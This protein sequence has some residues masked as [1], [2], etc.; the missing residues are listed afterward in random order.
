VAAYRSA[1]QT[2][3]DA[4]QAL[5]GSISAINFPP[6]MDADVRALLLES[7]NEHV[8]VVALVDA[9]DPRPDAVNQNAAAVNAAEQL[10]AHDLD[11]LAT[12]SSPSS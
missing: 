5:I 9:T 10:V 6:S 4:V 11:N 8:A 7:S 1:E 12:S 2:K 3:A